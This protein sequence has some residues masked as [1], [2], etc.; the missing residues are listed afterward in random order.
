ML[1]ERTEITAESL[2]SIKLFHDQSNYSIINPPPLRL[3]LFALHRLFQKVKQ[4]L[5][6]Q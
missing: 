1:E 3:L 4:D 5:V 6:C 2:V